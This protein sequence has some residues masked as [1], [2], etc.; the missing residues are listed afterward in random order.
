MTE[1][2]KRWPRFI[3]SKDFDRSRFNSSAE[4]LGFSSIKPVGKRDTVSYA[5]NK[6]KHMKAGLNEKLANAMEILNEAS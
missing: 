2:K 3:L 6:V 5:Q 4:P 1:N